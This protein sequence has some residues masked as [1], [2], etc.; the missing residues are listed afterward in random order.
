MGLIL[1]LLPFTQA[2]VIVAKIAVPMIT[3]NTLGLVLW[4]FL[5]HKWSQH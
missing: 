4:L 2:S 5:A 1:A 3:A